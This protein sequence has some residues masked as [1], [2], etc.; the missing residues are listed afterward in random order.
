MSILSAS[1]GETQGLAPSREVTRCRR[2]VGSRLWTTRETAPSISRRRHRHGGRHCD[3]C[4]RRD[5]HGDRRRERRRAAP[6]PHGLLLAS[7]GH[8]VHRLLVVERPTAHDFGADVVQG[9]RIKL[10]GVGLLI[11][12]RTRVQQPR[13]AHGRRARSQGQKQRAASRKRES[14]GDHGPRIVGK[15]R[16]QG[17]RSWSERVAL[18]SLPASYPLRRNSTIA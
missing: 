3:R 2:P 7:P 5:R 12:G 17:K 8:F 14:A 6:G 9:I 10:F 1:R 4:G 18:L 16:R 11:A 13:L 15:P